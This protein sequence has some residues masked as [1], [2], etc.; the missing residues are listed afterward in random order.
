MPI[1]S[2][3]GTPAREKHERM[4][5]LSDALRAA[6]RECPGSPQASATAATEAE[7]SV[8]AVNTPSRQPSSLERKRERDESLDVLQVYWFETVGKTAANSVRIS[9][10]G[11]DVPTA[12]LCAS[13]RNALHEPRAEHQQFF[14]LVSS[15]VPL[16]TA[17]TSKVSPSARNRL[18]MAT[19]FDRNPPTL[20]FFIPGNRSG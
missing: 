13:D 8:A 2:G 17:Y 18:S 3:D 12:G 15:R 14:H 10:H 19:N 6:S 20:A 1:K 16:L 4:R 9:V 11:N 7:K 5:T